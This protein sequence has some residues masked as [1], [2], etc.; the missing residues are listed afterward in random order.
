MAQI[1][2]SGHRN[3]DMDSIASAIAYSRLKNIL[4]GENQY[5]P[6]ALGPLNVQSKAVLEGLG[7]PS[8]LFVK[9]VFSR[10]CSV[11]RKPTMVL[12]PDDPVYELVNIVQPEQSFSCHD[13]GR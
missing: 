9:D 8:P 13:N 11:Y 1:Y 10:V 12:D 7:I 2:V 5:V 6:I 3:P 4:D